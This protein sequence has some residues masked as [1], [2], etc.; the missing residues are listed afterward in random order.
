MDKT[1]MLPCPFCEAAGEVEHN[2]GYQWWQAGCSKCGC[3]VSEI[4]CGCEAD[5]I[6]VWNNRVQHAEIETIVKKSAAFDLMLTAGY[7]TE[8]LAEQSLEVVET[9]MRLKSAR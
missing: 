3:R 1:E 8:E 9:L 4:G 5:A 6:F 7:V 2:E